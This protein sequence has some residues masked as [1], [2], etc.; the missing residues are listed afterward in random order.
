[1]FQSAAGTPVH[2]TKPDQSD[3]APVKPLYS[4]PPGAHFL[5]H[6]AQKPAPR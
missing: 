2:I 1:M 3:Q 6:A 4:V 5:A